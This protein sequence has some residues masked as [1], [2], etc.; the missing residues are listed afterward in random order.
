M[1]EL[2]RGTVTFLF[3]DIEGSTRLWQAHPAAMGAAIARHDALLRGSVEA[4]GGVVFKTVGDAVCA[5][6]ASAPQAVQAALAAQ[7]TLACQTWGA[8]G[9][10]GVRMALHSGEADAREGDY[11]GQPLNRV[12]R[13][14]AAGHGGQVLLSLATH[15]LVRD[16]LPSGT[17]LQDLGEHRLKDLSHPERVLQLLHPDLPT[18]FPP[19]KSLDRQ[20]H[21]L[22]LQ[23]T[24]LV[25]RERE[26]T[27]VVDLLAR[28]GVRLVTLTGPGGT[29]KTRLALQV[30]ADL[31]DTSPD[32]VWFV[33]LALLTEPD[34]LP[35][36]IAA[37][38][39]VREEGGQ[40]LRETLAA[41]LRTKHLLLVLDNL[42]QVVAGAPIIAS[43]MA[44]APGLKVLATSRVPLRLRG[45]YEVAV[46][47][48]ALPDLNRPES[49]EHLTQYAAVR[50]FIQ[51][52]TAA[53]AT[54]EVTNANAPAVAE[55]CVRLDGLPLAIELAA[56]RS[57][58]LPPQAM[59]A[60][61][62]RRLGL[63]TG[64]ARDLPERQQTLRGAIAWSYDLLTPDEQ[65]LFR[66]LAVCAGAFGLDAAEVIAGTPGSEELELDVLDGL[67]RLVD[68]SLLR[69]EEVA[70]GEPRF[71]MLETIRE[72]ALGELVA[73]G[74]HDDVAPRHAAYFGDLV[75][76]AEVP[77]WDSSLPVLDLVTRLETDYANA[78]AALGWLAAND[79]IA[80]VRLAGALCMFW[81]YRGHLVEGRR[82]LEGALTIAARLDDA[83]PAA[84]HASVLIASGLICQEQGELARAQALHEQGLAQAVE[85]R[86]LWRAAIARSLLGGALVSEG[87]YDA[88]E[89][90]F[91]A[92]RVQWQALDRPVWVG[93]A[94]FHL[95]LVAYAHRDWARAVP[96]LTD[97][98]RLQDTHGGEIEAT[99]PLHYLA[100]IACERRDIRE[101]AGIMT[102]VL[103][104]LRRRG[105]DPSLADGLADV[106]TLAAI[107][108]DVAA[109]ARL[110][111]TAA[112]LLEIGGT[113]YSLPGR[114]T[115]EQAEAAARQALTEEGWQNMFAAGRAMPTDRALAE[116]E[117][118]LTAA[119]ED[120]GDSQLL[121]AAGD[122]TDNVVP[123]NGTP[124]PAGGSIR[125]PWGCGQG[126]T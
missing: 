66:R 25:G 100:F 90:L 94:L 63:L 26:V 44:A 5:A 120:E 47:P 28:E 126:S 41:F 78:R 40:P 68:H 3:T 123:Q 31:L 57:K 86:D 32:G 80:H 17:G 53:K 85:A 55:I 103:R 2:P 117:E 124:G 101:A 8:T 1:P 24:P 59:L 110:F 64:G 88:A 125:S 92:A 7:R 51:R 52:A 27:D 19:L 35:G 121:R 46:P 111:G 14:L 104:R 37:V 99:D 9:P 91:Q 122:T 65:A 30:A 77:L 39:G 75:Q 115:Y 82:W 102:D 29:G 107:R 95:G 45:E 67:G 38:L 10:L 116:A 74:E 76:R 69:Q 119:A 23:P 12:A 58:L 106:A 70:G 81:Y 97:A 71:G 109:A 118:V 112:R 42:E 18:D 93:H 61:L 4:H 6:F 73:S 79:P 114:E 56:A 15:E 83:L 54:F 113:T 72:F 62:E 105:S 50:L 89:P 13:L 34:L 108:G 43:L 36:A 21:N 48:L 11:V 84:D 16:A 87:R 96:L 98:V 60:R 20:P 49:P 22:P 33:D